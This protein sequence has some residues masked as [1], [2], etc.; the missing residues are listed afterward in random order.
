VL[1]SG[2]SR[3]G[4]LEGGACVASL[5]LIPCRT[6]LLSCLSVAYDVG[7]FRQADRVGI[8]A[9]ACGAGVVAC[10]AVPP[11][12]P[13]QICAEGASPITLTLTP[14]AIFVANGLPPLALAW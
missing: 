8:L 10:A 9:L 4:E 2:G 13:W 7:S 14:N 1:A 6:M 12:P 3:I 11:P 5:S